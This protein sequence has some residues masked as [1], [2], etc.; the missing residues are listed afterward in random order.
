MSRSFSG[1]NPEVVTA[2]IDLVPGE[3]G[4]LEILLIVGGGGTNNKGG[5]GGARFP[6][7][8][9][10]A[11]GGCDRRRFEDPEWL[12]CRDDDDRTEEGNEATGC[13]SLLRELLPAVRG[14]PFKSTDGR[15]PRLTL[16]A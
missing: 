13:W 7:G 6:L 11:G 1:V 2:L 10:A 8:I 12:T 14:R 16:G 4:G 5:P 15:G 3:R 9:G